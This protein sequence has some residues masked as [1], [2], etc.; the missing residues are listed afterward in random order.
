VQTS[1]TGDSENHDGR[2]ESAEDGGM[3]KGWKAADST[4]KE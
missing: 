3:G 1:T 4:I 2:K